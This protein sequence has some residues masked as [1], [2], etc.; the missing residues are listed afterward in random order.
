M[1]LTE[2]AQILAF[3]KLHKEFSSHLSA[4]IGFNVVTKLLK[5]SYFSLWVKVFIEDE[6]TTRLPSDFLDKS[7]RC[8]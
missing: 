3:V 1:T 7:E 6:S 5:I 2:A 8:K 4:C